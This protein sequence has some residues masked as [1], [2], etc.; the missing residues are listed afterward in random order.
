LAQGLHAFFGAIDSA[1]IEFKVTVVTVDDQGKPTDWMYFVPDSDPPR[2]PISVLRSEW[3]AICRAVARRDIVVVEDIRAE[4]AKGVQGSYACED[5]G[6][7]EEGSL[8]CYP[9]FDLRS[10]TTPYAI[11]VVADKKKYFVERKSPIYQWTLKRFALRIRLE[12]YLLLLKQKA[13]AYDSENEE[14][15]EGC[16]KGRSVRQVLSPRFV[17][18]LHEKKRERTYREKYLSGGADGFKGVAPI[19]FFFLSPPGGRPPPRHQH[20]PI[21]KKP[22]RSGVCGGLVGARLPGTLLVAGKFPEVALERVAG[23]L[24]IHSKLTERNQEPAKVIDALVL[25]LLVVGADQ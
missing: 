1:D 23:V 24:Q 10:A 3:S 8:V 20:I 9:V 11:T 19:Q 4:A 18:L 25:D 14:F 22:R 17:G 16:P 13:D 6:S 2:T 7:V 5:A 15:C 21:S 12:H